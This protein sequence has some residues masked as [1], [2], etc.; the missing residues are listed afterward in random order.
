MRRFVL[1]ILAATAI[2]HSCKNHPQGDC[3]AELDTLEYIKTTEGSSM[4]DPAVL[5]GAW[6]EIADS[7]LGLTINDSVRYRQPP[8]VAYPYVLRNDSLFISVENIPFSAKII[9]ATP[10]SLVLENRGV[11]TRYAK[12]GQ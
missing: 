1:A 4:I 12:K 8:G 9:K 11:V 10:D 3:C 7:T 5:K 6:E 2:I